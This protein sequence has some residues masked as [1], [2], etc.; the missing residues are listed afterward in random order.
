M[1]H[2]YR[3]SVSDAV[4]QARTSLRLYREAAAAAPQP[5]DAAGPRRVTLELPLPTQR[6]G[7][8]RSRLAWASWCAGISVRAGQDPVTRGH[9]SCR[10]C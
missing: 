10:R 6:S 1:P 9:T 2:K 8:L 7:F 5:T 3:R 4:R